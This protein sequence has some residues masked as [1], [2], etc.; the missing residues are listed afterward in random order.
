MR[1]QY[2]KGG[3]A[4]IPGLKTGVF[5]L[6]PLH[7]RKINY[8]SKWESEI[9]ARIKP[10][11]STEEYEN[12]DFDEYIKNR[13]YDICRLPISELCRRAKISRP[14]IWHV[15]EELYQ[16]KLMDYCPGMLFV[17]HRK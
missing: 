6:R 11:L 10:K 5:P 1:K 8:Y 12:K 4:F 16:M 15:I 3:S 9:K 2:Q 13:K 7:P 17:P 14:Y